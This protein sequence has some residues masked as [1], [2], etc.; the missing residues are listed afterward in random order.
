MK[1]EC[2]VQSGMPPMTQQ[3]Y[4]NMNQP[5]F[6]MNQPPFGMNYPSMQSP[7]GNRGDIFGSMPSSFGC[8]TS[9]KFDPFCDYSSTGQGSDVWIRN[10]LSTIP[11]GYL[12]NVLLSNPSL[13]SQ[14]CNN[15]SQCNPWM[16]GMRNP[17][18]DTSMGSNWGQGMTGMEQYGITQSTLMDRSQVQRGLPLHHLSQKIWVPRADIID[19]GDIIK[20]KVELPGVKQDEIR[21]F[22]NNNILTVAPSKPVVNVQEIL[23]KKGLILQYEGHLGYFFRRLCLPERVDAARTSSEL[24][25][26]VLKIFLPKTT[27]QQG[28]SI[29]VGGG[30]HAKEQQQQQQSKRRTEANVTPQQK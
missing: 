19:K 18:F 29:Q 30:V 21:V 20:V 12:W 11:S 17:C 5:P 24:K 13:L 2:N 14:C 4:G 26:G 16:G 28:A 10:L 1:T 22:V 7:F 25:D 3:S 23:Q 8:D 15:W 6:G 27:E 9:S